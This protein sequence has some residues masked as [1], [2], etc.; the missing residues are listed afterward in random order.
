MTAISFTQVR[1]LKGREQCNLFR[2][3]WKFV[4][5][6]QGQD[7]DEPFFTLCGHSG[8]RDVLFDQ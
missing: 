7:K 3:T 5:P 8:V 4:C 6:F 2:V 1:N